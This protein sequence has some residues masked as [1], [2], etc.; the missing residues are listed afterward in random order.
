MSGATSHWPPIE[1]DSTMQSRLA[2]LLQGQRVNDA[3]HL[4]QQRIASGELFDPR[5]DRQW[6][7]IAD[8]IAAIVS[9]ASGPDATIPFWEALLDF[10]THAIEPVWGHA[11]K[12][13]IYFRLANAV[14][15]HDPA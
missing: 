13:H 10:F 8:D 1:S 2:N 7:P 5:T 11:H 6:A 12:G 3:R 9:D 4:L 15:R 14:A